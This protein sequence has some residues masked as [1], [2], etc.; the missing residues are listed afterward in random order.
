MVGNREAWSQ[1]CVCVLL[2]VRRGRKGGG[3]EANHGRN[4][5]QPG[6]VLFT[7]AQG[8]GV[9]APPSRSTFLLGAG[10]ILKAAEVTPFGLPN[11]RVPSTDPSPAFGARPLSSVTLGFDPPA[12]PA[13]VPPAPPGVGP[14]RPPPTRV[15]LVGRGL[16]SAKRRSFFPVERFPRPPRWS[17]R[18]SSGKVSTPILPLISLI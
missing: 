13:L 5:C 18:A 10:P 14:T 6:F 16:V 17:K 8:R 12:P 4:Q 15:D 2:P 9:G 7:S 11:S 3:E 1:C